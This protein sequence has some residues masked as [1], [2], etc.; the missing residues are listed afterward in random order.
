M[1]MRGK[2]LSLCI[3]PLIITGILCE[4]I[5][6]SQYTS[7]MYAEIKESL[8][9]SAIAALN[10]YNSQGYGDYAKKEDGAVWRG[11]NFNVSQESSIVDNIKDETGVD[12]T[13][14]YEN[15]AAMTSMTDENGGRYIGMQTGKNITNYTLKQG[16]Q[17]Y[18]RTIDIGGNQYHAYIIPITQPDSGNVIGALMATRS[19]D[20]LNQL[21][22]KN[23]MVLVGIICAINLLFVI[24]AILF[25]NAVVKQI[26]TAGNAVKK[27]ST[28]DL[29]NPLKEKKKRR[30]ELGELD[31]DIEALQQKLTEIV[32]T[33]QNS[34]GVLKSAAVELNDTADG[35]LGAAKEMSQAVELISQTTCEQAS[36]SQN[37]SEHMHHMDDMLNSSMREVDE[38]HTLSTDMH[39]LSRDTGQILDELQESNQKSKETLQVIYEQTNT[40]NSSVQDIKTATEFITSIAEETNLLALNA[41][42]EAARAGESGKGFAVVAHEI[43]GLAEQTNT[44]AEQIQ[45][46]VATL[47]EKTEHTVAAMEL[48]KNTMDDQNQKVSDTQE[49]FDRLGENIDVSTRKI[50]HIA[51]LTKQIDTV[52]REMTSNMEK[53][54]SSAEGN[55]A[56]AEEA[57]AM[58]AQVSDEFAKVSELA[59]QLQELASRLEQDI[60]FFHG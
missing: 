22:V 53:F 7:G 27:V 54:S 35:T 37:V 60:S 33:I 11:M 4:V 16:A 55:A 14:F 19:V 1:K 45:S 39:Q 29:T 21:I 51:D 34:S 3:I 5:G 43:Q 48:V 59:G 26:R 57:S 28:G 8:K 31:R 6:I 38:I 18:Y 52:K 23:A 36:E 46:I 9:A 12:I 24:C 30:D 17:M 25:V 40:T 20:R 42:I 15:T 44:R 13:F 47:V 41:S 58:T 2:I 32:G 49:S 50:V 56:A 10:V